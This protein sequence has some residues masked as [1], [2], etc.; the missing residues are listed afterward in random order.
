MNEHVAKDTLP[1]VPE[2]IQ[3][4]GQSTEENSLRPRIYRNRGFESRLGHRCF[5]VCPVFL[6]WIKLRTKGPT[7]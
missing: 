1:D 7:V 5:C 4:N 2:A 3:Y 6:Q